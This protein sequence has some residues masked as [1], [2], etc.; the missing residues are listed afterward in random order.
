[1]L[2]SIRLTTLLTALLV[3]FAACGDDDGNGGPT[4]P[5]GPSDAQV[6]GSWTYNAS[7]M[8]GTL[9]GTTVSCS[10]GGRAMNLNQTGSTFTGSTVGGTLTCTGGGQTLSEP[11]GSGVV[12][13]GSVNGSEVSFDFGT[14]DWRHQG[15]VSGSSMNG[16][17]TIS[18]QLDDQLVIL[19]GNW[20]AARQSSSNALLL[21]RESGAERTRSV[22]EV[23]R[24][25]VGAIDRDASGVRQG[26]R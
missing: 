19:N 9:S 22:E 4:G 6:G 15:T 17:V 26:T 16:T 10:I 14:S 3:A 1:M 8:T 20:A 12:V 21:M 5:S 18:I 23:W 13:N 2:R 7:N 11:L 25:L 24:A